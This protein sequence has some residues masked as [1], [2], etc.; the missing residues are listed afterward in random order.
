M[1][2]AEPDDESGVQRPTAT[3]RYDVLTD[4]QLEI[5]AAMMKL[6]TDDHRLDVMY[7]FCK[8]CGRVEGESRY[9][10]GYCQCANDD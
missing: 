7:Y 1:S 5:I 10:G 3:S 8:K 2:T 9:T 4:D 6:P